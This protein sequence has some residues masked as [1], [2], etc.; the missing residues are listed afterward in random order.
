MPILRAVAQFSSALVWG[1]KGRECK[2]HRLD[3]SP[4]SLGSR[5]PPWYGGDPS[6]TLGEGS[7][8]P[9]ARVS[10]VNPPVP[11]DAPPPARGSIDDAECDPSLIRTEGG[12][13]S[14]RRYQTVAVLTAAQRRCSA[15]AP[16][17]VS[18]DGS[19]LNGRV[20]GESPSAGCNSFRRYQEREPDERAGSAS[21]AAGPE[22]VGVQVLRVPC[23]PM[24]QWPSSEARVCKARSRGCNSPLALPYIQTG[25]SSA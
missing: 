2:S 21:K 1:T 9:L 25:R 5:V 4:H 24:S 11:T 17:R 19:G 20:G 23:F 22:R 10:P 15:G 6:A 7:R 14:H 16:E 12:C 3:S 8:S 13:D 18:A